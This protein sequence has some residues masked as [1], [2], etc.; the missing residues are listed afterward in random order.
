MLHCTMLH[1]FIRHTVALSL[2]V[3][4][5]VFGVMGVIAVPAY[6]AFMVVWMHIPLQT[7]LTSTLP[8]AIACIALSWYCGKTGIQKFRSA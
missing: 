4:A 2:A 3:I 7:I 1:P 6:A 8:V 5:L